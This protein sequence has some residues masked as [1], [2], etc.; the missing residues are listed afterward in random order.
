MR[1]LVVEGILRLLLAAA[2]EHGAVV[3]LEDLHDADPETFEFLHHATAAIA[4]ERLLILGSVRTLERHAGETRARALGRAGQA[5]I[6]EVG[7]LDEAGIASLAEAALEAR[8]P[9]ELIADLVARTDG[10]PLLVEEMLDAHLDAGSLRRDGASVQWSPEAR[11]VVPRTIVELTR[12]R[13][14]RLKSDD[15]C[16]VMAGAVLGRFDPALLAAVTGLG[17]A[18]V[19]S[20]LQRAVEEGLLEAATVAFRHALLR[21]AVVENATRL[22]RSDLHQRAAEVLDALHGEEPEWL[23]ERAHHREAIG[24]G[25][26]AAQLLIEAGRRSLARHAP[27]SAEIVLGRAIALARSPSVA[28]E[29]RD[30]LVET[31][32][33][34]GRWEEA[35]GI[36]RRLLASQGEDAARLERMARHAVALL[37]AQGSQAHF[38]ESDEL[39]ARAAAARAE[40][41]RLQVLSALVSL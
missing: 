2:Q 37:G 34:L 27:A 15:R 28:D 1:L 29:G 30:V 6:I 38:E 21:D 41:V 11:S 23:E 33:R 16:P 20:G 12:E 13:L 10:V 26:G 14:S 32:G 22:E 36:D 17:E 5:T 24:D 19:S 39:I 40:P 31:L 25:D 4:Y 18:A 35:L 9:P 7:H 8:P 3:I